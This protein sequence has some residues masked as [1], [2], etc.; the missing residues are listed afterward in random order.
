MFEE[1]M[2]HA[3]QGVS[4]N[5]EDEELLNCLHESSCRFTQRNTWNDILRIQ[6]SM[7]VT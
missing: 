7:C 4:S 5:T 2:G 6:N 3:V 1:D